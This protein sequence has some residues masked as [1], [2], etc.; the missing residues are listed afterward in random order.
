MTDRVTTDHLDLPSPPSGPPLA[1]VQGTGHQRGA[2]AASPAH[3]KPT[4][5]WRCGAPKRDGSGPCPSPVAGPGRHCPMH[6][7]T[8]QAEVAEAR[9]R[10][11]ATTQALT[12]RGAA[13]G[14]ENLSA[15][16]GTPEGVQRVLEQTANAVAAGRLS[17]NAGAVL[18]QLARVA[19][20]LAQARVEKQVEQLVAEVERLAAERRR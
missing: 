8:R 3:G 19:V 18:A 2:R 20:E 15:D 11:G 1:N 10:G 14:V 9:K 6:D 12:R 16:L 7:P 13:Y 17:A 4:G 5:G